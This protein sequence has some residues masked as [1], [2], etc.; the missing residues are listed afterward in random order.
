MGRPPIGKVAMTGA[1]RVRRHRLKHR[2]GDAKLGAKPPGAATA[3]RERVRPVTKPEAPYDARSPA[4]D[5]NDP[6]N[7]ER[8]ETFY[9]R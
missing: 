2:S 3:E 6:A 1:E 7:S 4:E 5:N 8:V 9:R